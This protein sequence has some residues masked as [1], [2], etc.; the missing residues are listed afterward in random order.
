MLLFAL[1]QNS[2]LWLLD[3]TLTGIKNGR[4]TRTGVVAFA[5]DITLLVTDPR[6]IPELAE[7]LRRYEKAKG[8]CLNIRK[9]KAMAAGSW[10]TTVNTMTSHIARKRP[11]WDSNLQARL[12]NP[13]RA[14]GRR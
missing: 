5:D 8:A 1:C 2:L 13:V 9:P 3:Q 11:S 10:N 4:G 6:D 7:T 12:T 14:A